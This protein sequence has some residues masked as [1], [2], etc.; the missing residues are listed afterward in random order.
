MCVRFGSIGASLYSLFQ[1]MTLEA[2]S[3]GIVRPLME[4]YPFAWMFFVPFI[5]IT[6]FIVATS[7]GRHGR[8]NR[9]KI[10]E[11]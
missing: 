11:V 6:S 9:S 8:Q 5:L 4:I 7:T 2:W 10:I 1:I 3:D